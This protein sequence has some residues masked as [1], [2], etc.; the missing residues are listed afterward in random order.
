LRSSIGVRTKLGKP[1]NGLAPYGYKGEDKHLAL[2]PTEAAVR[3]EAFEL[4][5]THRRKGVVARMLHE[6]GHRTRSGKQFADT[7]SDRML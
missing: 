7:H 6:K 1:L 2:V 5:L 4:F 3:R